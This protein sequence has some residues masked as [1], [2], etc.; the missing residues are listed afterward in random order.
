MHKPTSG[1]TGP[2][3]CIQHRVCRSILC[4]AVIMVMVC[5]SSNVRL[6]CGTVQRN[7]QSAPSFAHHLGSR[8]QSGIGCRH[9]C[10][11]CWVWLNRVWNRTGPPGCQTPPPVGCMST[12]LPQ[13]GQLTP[14]TPAQHDKES[15]A[16]LD[17]VCLSVQG[18]QL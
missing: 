15:L 8:C 16:T 11:L 3:V 10:L 18:V 13:H 6:R 5:D 1:C 14:S 9:H 2:T 7:T 4:H 12:A 17:D